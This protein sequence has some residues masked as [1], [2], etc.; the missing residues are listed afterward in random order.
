MSGRKIS[1]VK[2]AQE[3]QLKLNLLSDINIS[4]ANIN[5]LAKTINQTLAKSPQGVKAVFALDVQRATQWQEFAQKVRNRHKINDSDDVLL[6]AKA[7]YNRQKDEGQD[8]LDILTTNLLQKANAI[9]KNAALKLSQLESTYNSSSNG[10][11]EWF[12]Q[13]VLAD[14]ERLLKNVEKLLEQ[15]R[16]NEIDKALAETE[17]YISATVQELRNLELQY[18]KRSYVY[19]AL[20]Q[21]CEEMNFGVRPLKPE[22]QASRKRDRL[23]YV[24]NTYTDG[25]ITFYLSLDD[26]QTDSQFLQKECISKFGE[27]SGILKEKF[28]VITKFTSGDGIPDEHLIQKN[29][30][31]TPTDDNMTLNAE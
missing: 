1:A 27:M 20:K 2:L 7:Q 10:I 19:D 6:A 31:Q 11:S 18:Q 4:I 25:E 17:K 9:E 13:S 14:C 26:I 24:V 23:V 21:V 5:G 3:R 30:L 8:L 15:H 22:Q 28:G 12:E 29:E 16:L